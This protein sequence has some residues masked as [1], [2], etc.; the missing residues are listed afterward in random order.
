MSHEALLLSSLK[1]DRA[2]LISLDE[3]AAGYKGFRAGALTLNKCGYPGIILPPDVQVSCL[4]NELQALEFNRVADLMAANQDVT[5]PE[6]Q[7]IIQRVW[8]PVWEF[9]ELRCFLPKTAIAAADRTD[10]GTIDV[11]RLRLNP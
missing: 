11:S 2:Q 3:S 10:T 1:I 9:A 8:G 5:G 4:L 7:G 6:A